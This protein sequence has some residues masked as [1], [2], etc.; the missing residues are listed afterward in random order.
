MKFLEQFVATFYFWLLV[1]LLA[2]S[3]PVIAIMVLRK[4]ESAPASKS[5]PFRLGDIFKMPKFGRAKKSG[6]NFAEKIGEKVVSWMIE[7]SRTLD[8]V[9]LR[10]LLSKI[11]KEC[12]RLSGEPLPDENKRII[13]TVLIW[14][15]NFDIE[16]HVNEMTL[17]HNSTQIVYDSKKRDFKLMIVKNA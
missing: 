14:S 12:N 13:S 2:A 11:T 6:G 10:E 5:A 7:V 17:F 8:R 15:N 1:G 4:K 16:K 9:K 3:I